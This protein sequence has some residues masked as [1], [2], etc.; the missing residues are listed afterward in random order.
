MDETLLKTPLADEH[1]AIGARMVPFAGW[2]MPVQYK[3][4]ILAEHKYTREHVSLFDICHMGEFKAAGAGAAEALDAAL[5]RSV[6]D[7]KDGV[8]RYN[9]L[10]NEAGGVI[11][12]LIVYRMGAEDFFIV[13]NAARIE[14][15]FIEL[16]KRLPASV[17]LDNLSETTAKFDL[18][19]PD[20][21]S[22]LTSLG[23]DAAALPKYYHWAKFNLFGLD[24]L[25]SRTGYTGELGFELY[26]DAAHAVEVW[27]KLLACPGVKPAGL[28]ARDTLRLEMGYPLYGDEMDESTTPVEAGFGALLKL[29]KSDRMFVGS[30]ALRA[31]PPK[32]HLRGIVLEGR[33]AAHTGTPLLLDGKQVGTITS[34]T[35]AP[36]LG[37]AVAMAYLDASAVVPE[38]AVFDVELH[39]AVVKA[40]L[41][42]LPF[43]THGTANPKS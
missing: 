27:R 33:R 37:C 7:Q 9:F 14:V 16:R 35:F 29:D 19:G 5:A 43:W 17:R 40:K 28:G 30:K 1:V 41:A 31:N 12:D 2:Y 26:F 32:K 15:D 34:G 42:P 6:A 23:L 10:L 3:E 4:G 22:V 13:V 24:M 36:S 21:I 39:R 20:S 25:I 8:C 38:D 11:D 18:Q